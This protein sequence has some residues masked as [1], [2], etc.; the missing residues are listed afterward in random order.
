MNAHPKIAATPPQALTQPER[1][2]AVSP[3]NP[4]MRLF[5]V[6]RFVGDIG[7]TLAY[8][9]DD[10]GQH[11]FLVG[12]IEGFAD[13]V[14]LY[15]APSTNVGRVVSTDHA[16]RFWNAMHPWAALSQAD[17]VG[18]SAEQEQSK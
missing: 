18:R 12:R 17:G 11:D 10:L 9:F 2:G 4:F 15:G 13:P 7:T 6:Y 5:P 8:F 16:N 1:T 14:K 3:L